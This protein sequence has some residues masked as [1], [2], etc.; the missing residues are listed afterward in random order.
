MGSSPRRGAGAAPSD[1]PIEDLMEKGLRLLASGRHAQARRQFEKILA[2]LPSHT[3]ARIHLAGT[4][5]AEGDYERAAGHAEAVLEAMP[6]HVRALTVVAESYWRAGEHD[7]ARDAADRASRTLHALV[8]SGQ[9]TRGDVAAVVRVLARLEDDRGLEVIGRRYVR[10]NPADWDGLTLTLLGVAAWNTNRHRD[11]RWLWRRAAQDPFLAGLIPAFL[12]ALDLVEEHAVPPFRLEYWWGSDGPSPARSRPD[13]Y[14]KAF[15][16]HTLWT[17]DDREAREAA[18]DLLAQSE[19][20]WAEPFLFAFLC[21][22]DVPDPLKLRASGWLLE[23]GYLKPN[24][25]VAMHLDG[26][27][28]EVTISATP[29]SAPAGTAVGP[30]EGSAAAKGRAAEEPVRERERAARAEPPRRRGRRTRVEAG[31]PWE[32]GLETLSRSHLIAM[33]RGFGLRGVSRLTKGE[34]A[35]QVAAWLRANWTELM[36]LLDDDDVALLRWMAERGG[37]VPLH[38]LVERVERRTEIRRNRRDAGAQGPFGG[39]RSDVRLQA[40]GFLFVGALA[41]DNGRTEAAVIPPEVCR[42]LGGGPSDG[43]GGGGG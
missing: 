3:D 11:A 6:E 1:E 16:L 8:R 17:S 40:L 4:Y 33:A 5:L 7:R 24:T 42:A 18:L 27:L 41:G 2:R 31:M 43:P 22:P 35:T 36:S 23:R 10:G 14:M 26:D 37:V 28:R 21:R 13:G 38:R 19:S 34:I 9:A 39:L 15:S 12:H 32:T 25:P 29:R 30:G 20:S